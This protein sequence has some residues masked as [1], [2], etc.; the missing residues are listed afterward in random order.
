VR[1][2][3]VPPEKKVGKLN[4]NNRWNITQIS[5]KQN[6][7]KWRDNYLTSL[8]ERQKWQHKEPNLNIGEMV[9]IKDEDEAQ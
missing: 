4:L 8:Q 1:P 3:T 6:W 9:L 5:R 2:F 7:E